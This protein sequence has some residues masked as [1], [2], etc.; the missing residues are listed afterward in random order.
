[1]SVSDRGPTV[2]SPAGNTETKPSVQERGLA[3]NVQAKLKDFPD[4][5]KRLGDIAA[6]KRS[7]QDGHARK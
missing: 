3:A 2:T 5:K 4:Q 7:G 6:K 1:M